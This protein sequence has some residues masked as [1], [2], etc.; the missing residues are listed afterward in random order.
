M[1]RT[2]PE[3]PTACSQPLRRMAACTGSSSRR[4]ATRSRPKRL[5]EMRPSLKKRSL[6]ADASHAQ[7]YSSSSGVRPS[8]MVQAQVRAAADINNEALSLG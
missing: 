7:A 2:V 5:A 1:A 8:P 4:A 3:L 6:D